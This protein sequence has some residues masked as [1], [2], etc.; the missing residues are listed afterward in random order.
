MRALYEF[1]IIFTKS[2]KKRLAKDSEAVVPS[3]NIDELEYLLD[4]N[5]LKIVRSIIL[6]GTHICLLANCSARL[7]RLR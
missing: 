7:V 1:E 2:A 6:K 5:I 3:G 4:E